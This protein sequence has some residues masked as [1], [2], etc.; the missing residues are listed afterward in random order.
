[1]VDH[2]GR[3]WGGFGRDGA[4]EKVVVVGHGGVV[5]EGGV[6]G[7]ASVFKEDVLGYAVF[8]GATLRT[9]QI[10]ITEQDVLKFISVPAVNRF[11]LSTT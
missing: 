6:V 8:I 9:S 2:I 7:G 1:M 10:R 5:E 11:S 4:E 3:H